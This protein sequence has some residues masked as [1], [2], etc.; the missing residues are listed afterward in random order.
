MVSLAAPTIEFGAITLK[1]ATGKYRYLKTSSSTGHK[2]VLKTWST[3]S[4]NSYDASNSG[5]YECGY[6]VTVAAGASAV[7]TVRLTPEE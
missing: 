6:E 4:N 3:V 1:S 5:Y 7:I 2:P